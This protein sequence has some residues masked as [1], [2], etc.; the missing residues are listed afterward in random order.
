LRPRTVLT[1]LRPLDRVTGGLRPGQ[2]WLHA[3]GVGHLKTTWAMNWA[4]NAVT[5]PERAVNVLFAS[6][7][8]SSEQIDGEFIA[9]HKRISFAKMRRRE[10]DATEVS[11]LRGAEIELRERGIPGRF[12]SKNA[13]A[14]MSDLASGD[15]PLDMLIVDDANLVRP[16]RRTTEPPGS[17]AAWTHP[18]ERLREVYQ[19]AKKLALGQGPCKPIAILMLHQLNRTAI[20]NR[21]EVLPGA[22]DPDILEGVDVVTTSWQDPM[23]TR[24]AL[25]MFQMLKNRNGSLAPPFPVDID[26]ETRRMTY[27]LV[28]SRQAV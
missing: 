7:D 16:E 3:A 17:P 11:I 18:W 12:E 6:I 23:L 10:L 21:G 2:V 24:H 26:P 22:I 15:F 25:V 28:E 4:V 27:G 13:W 8:K 14:T 1:G 19:D 20:S 5:R 9:M